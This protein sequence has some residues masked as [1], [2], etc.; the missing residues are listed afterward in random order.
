MYNIDK[1]NELVSYVKQNNLFY[2]E[3]YN[4]VNIPLKDIIELP[5]LQRIAIRSNKDKIISKG[6]NVNSLKHDKTNGTTEKIP[7]DIYKTKSE[8]ISLD[9]LLWSKRRNFN[10]DATKRYAFYYYNGKDFS[11]DNTVIGKQENIIIHFPMRKAN[12]YKFVED[13]LL[14]IDKKIEWLICP[15][16]I[17]LVLC[18]IAIKYN[19]DLK[20]KVVELISEYLP[21]AY[22]LLIEKVFDCKTCIHYSCHEIWGMAFSDRDGKLKIMDDIILEQKQDNRFMKNYGCCVVTNL[23]LKSMP[24]IRYEL[25]DLI[26]ID[27]D[28]IKTYGFR[29]S[30]KV[31]LENF[32]IHCSFFD[33]IFLEFSDYVL[34][35]LENYQIIYDNNSIYFY[36]LGVD[37]AIYKTIKDFV[38]ENIYKC[39][40]QKVN[41]EMISSEKFYTDKISG[42]MRGIIKYED[43]NWEL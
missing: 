17:A 36:L 42:K 32:E 8:W 25:N 7:L 19:I 40:S 27:G 10:V 38:S 43:V 23:R 9:L 1:L 20:L 5:L 18:N 29:I 6:F 16:S 33:N 21:E 11:K 34:L 30:E 39:F 3:L 24:F 31:I 28:S 2:N 22:K 26:S 4:N 14:M 12:E 15:P 37:S 41:I 35:P 13:L